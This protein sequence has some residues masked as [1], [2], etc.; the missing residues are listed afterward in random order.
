MLRITH[1]RRVIT[2]YTTSEAIL[3]MPGTRFESVPSALALVRSITWSTSQ[4]YG[5]GFMKEMESNAELA[6]GGYKINTG[7]LVGERF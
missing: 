7:F 3:Q 6:K 2:E 5:C 1:N 4:T